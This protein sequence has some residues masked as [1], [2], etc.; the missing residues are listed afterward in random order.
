MNVKTSGSKF[1]LIFRYYCSRKQKNHA[2]NQIK[3]YKLAPISTQ[4][5]SM[6]KSNEQLLNDSHVTDR[7]MSTSFTLLD[8]NFNGGN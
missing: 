1:T 6:I 2:R 5:F 7:I 4:I 3:L 8:Q